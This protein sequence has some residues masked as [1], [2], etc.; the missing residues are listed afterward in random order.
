MYLTGRAKDVIIRGGHNIDPAT[1]EEA[2]LGH[3][4]VTAAA[5]VGRPDTHAGE[6][7]AA[8]VTVVP[9]A[10]VGV[11]ELASWAAAHVTECAAA[12]RHV[13]IVDVIPVTAVG[14]P[15][16]PALRAEAARAALATALDEIP[17]SRMS[18]PGS[19]METSRSRFASLPVRTENSSARH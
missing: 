6:V 1:V 13:T 4:D 9:G 15:Y 14:K 12:P 18:P 16:K 7:P 19:V 17:E 11:E 5:V 2:L 3:P 10:T 8:F